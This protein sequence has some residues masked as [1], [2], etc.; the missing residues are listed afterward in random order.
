MEALKQ[1]ILDAPKF[2]IEDEKSSWFG[3]E[4]CH[5]WEKE[6]ITLKEKSTKA[7]EPKVTFAIDSTKFNK[8][9]NV[10]NKK[11]KFV[12]MESNNKSHFHHHLTCHYC[13]KKGHTIAKC[14]FRRYL[15]PNGVECLDFMKRM[16]FL[17]SGC[18]RHTKGDISL[19]TDSVEKKKGYMTYGDNN[20]GDMLGKG[21]VGNLSSI[22]VSDVILIEGLKHNLLSISHYVTKSI[23]KLSQIVID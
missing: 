3:C 10:Q 19:F 18:L 21:S 6:V 16:L 13:Y 14:K 9:L 15:V 22:I 20:K 4:T 2:K 5:I 17:D 12:V 11:Y 23:K 1:T 7:L 8:S